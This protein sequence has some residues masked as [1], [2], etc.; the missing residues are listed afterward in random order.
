MMDK[1]TTITCIHVGSHDDRFAVLQDIGIRF[2]TIR[3]RQASLSLL[4]LDQIEPPKLGGCCLVEHV[5]LGVLTFR[6]QGP[7]RFQV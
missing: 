6:Y 7:A 4:I 3:P 2:V 5:V 1:L